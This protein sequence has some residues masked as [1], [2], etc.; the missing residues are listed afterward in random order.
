M[1]AYYNEHDPAAARWLRELMHEGLIA[2]GDVDERS[3]RDVRASDLRGY[4]QCHFFAGIGVWSHAL[5]GAGWAD[6][7]PVWTGSCPCQPFSA[8]GK[9]LGFADERHLWP[10]F[11][12]LIAERRPGVVFGEQVASAGAWVD[13]V[14]ADLED[15]GYAFAATDLPAAG[16]DG[17]H[18]RQRFYWVADADNAEWWSERAPR[19]DGDWPATGRIEGH[20]HAGDG[21]A[22]GWLADADREGSFAGRTASASNR[23][24]NTADT[25]G[26]AG[27]MGNT[28]LPRPQGWS[29]QS[30]RGDQRPLG[31]TG[32]AGGRR[33]A[34]NVLGRAADWIFCRDARWRPVEAGTFP[35]ATEAP[36]RVGR[37]RGYGNALDAVAAREF[38]AGYLDCAPAERVVA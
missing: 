15:R 22:A 38:I 7:R 24:R 13:L 11:L 32:V 19:N 26:C 17:A 6:D 1:S 34:S 10:E 30:E 33:G 2:R 31:E 25:D 23:Y 18:I 3:I 8:A 21:G 4:A 35:L 12:R 5:R 29:F 16:F 27:K 9:G 20:G 28:G 36:S 14:S 37:L